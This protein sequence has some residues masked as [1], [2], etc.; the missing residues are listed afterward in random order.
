MSEEAFKRLISGAT[1]GLAACCGRFLLRCLAVP[2]G[3]VMWLRNLAYDR[4]WKSETRASV[5]V[6]SVGNLTTGGTG[7]T[8]VVAT[9]V[10]MLQQMGYHPGI[11]SRGYK[12]DS[13]GHN[14]EQRVLQQL[15]PGV[16]HQQNPDRIAAAAALTSTTDT[17]VIVLDDGFQ[18]RRIARD[19]N[20]ILIDATNPFGY[21][22]LLP[23]G[24]LREPLAGLARA[25]LV[26]I[27]RSD[28]VSA[29]ALEHIKT[30]VIR[31]NSALTHRIAEVRFV[32]TGLLSHAGSHPLS[33]VQDQPAVLLT[34][35]GNPDAF[36]QTC[37][38]LGARIVSRRVFPDHH[39]YTAAEI[40]AA[41]QQADSVQA[42]VILTTLKDLV[43]IPD[44]A[45]S[46]RAV[47]I[48]TVFSSDAAEAGFRDR[49][50]TAVTRAHNCRAPRT[51]ES[52]SSDPASDSAI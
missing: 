50:R 47:Q 27:T 19:L 40:A 35:I 52:G 12:A 9:I 39:H 18:H 3:L 20:I 14:D 34:A 29:A 11:V 15:C 23:R 2:Y 36:E 46:V 21:G 10:R 4:R 17:D 8:P 6:I 51:A 22:Y 49:L 33:E 44:H 45:A 38:D 37:R 13:T 25:D 31:H 32:P 16:P 7:K 43:K 5:P 48:D 24:L 41:Q 1:S 42:T 28:A 30:R 26:L